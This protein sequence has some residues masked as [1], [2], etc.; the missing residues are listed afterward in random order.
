MAESELLALLRK[1]RARMRRVE[2]FYF[3][4]STS[5]I[6][7]PISTDFNFAIFYFLLTILITQ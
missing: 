5:I 7:L 1:Y 2:N 6:L 4:F 3:H